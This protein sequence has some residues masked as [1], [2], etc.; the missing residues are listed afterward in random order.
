M[1]TNDHYD[2]ENNKYFISVSANSSTLKTVL[3][4]S[5]GYQVDFG[6]PNSMR[7]VL[8]FNSAVYTAAYHE[9]DKKL[10]YCRGTAQR[11]C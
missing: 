10:C 3:T 8:G 7:H 4:L 9:S 5:N 6:L 1:R 11:A 2:D